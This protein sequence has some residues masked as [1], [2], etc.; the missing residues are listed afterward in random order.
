MWHHTH[1]HKARWLGTHSQNSMGKPSLSRSHNV[2]AQCGKLQ[3]TGELSTRFRRKCGE[4]YNAELA[5]LSFTVKKPYNECFHSHCWDLGERFRLSGLMVFYFLQILIRY[6]SQS[7]SLCYFYWKPVQRLCGVTAY[8][9]E[10]GCVLYPHASD[11]K[12]S[13]MSS[14]KTSSRE[15]EVPGTTLVEQSWNLL[16]TEGR[17]NR[18]RKRGWEI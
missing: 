10:E 2:L 17:N 7:F 3:S 5:F 15:R 14:Q 9:W 11:I 4:L 16:I 18:K 6:F 8:L 13:T 12:G 1:T